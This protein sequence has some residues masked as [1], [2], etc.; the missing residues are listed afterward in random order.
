M[1]VICV[2]DNHIYPDVFIRN[3]VGEKT[4][5]EIILKRVSVKERF[6]RFYETLPEREEL[7][8]FD[9][10]WEYENL[11]REI[12]S[13][14]KD[15]RIIH[16]FS[17]QIVRD[18][19]RDDVRILFEKA[20]LSDGNYV[21]KN[22][23]KN[24]AG[25]I[26]RK[27]S[28]YLEFLE[29]AKDRLTD[30]DVYQ[31]YRFEFFEM[32]AGG[33]FDISVYSNFRNYITGGFDARFFN[34]F[35]GDEY[36]VK[37]ISDKKEK[38][39]AEY[40]FYGLLPDDMKHWF[41]MPYDYGE[42]EN[43]AFYSM[44]RYHMTDLA[45][46]FVHGAIDLKEFEKLMQMVFY[47]LDSRAAKDISD[48]EYKTTADTLYVKKVK[49]RIEA[50]KKHPGYEKIRQL[51]SNRE[52][53]L[54]D[55]LLK[56]YLDL[57]EKLTAEEKLKSISVIGHGDLCFSN[58]LFDKNTELLMLIDPKGA[59]KEEDLWTDPYY[60]A[61]KLSHSV[62]GRYD[63]FNNGLYRFDLDDDLRPVL[64]IE[65]DNSEYV[66]VFREYL[67]R[68]GFSCRLV[69]LY[70]ASLFLSMLPLHMDYPKKVFGFMKNAEMILEELEGP[71]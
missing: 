29:L 49:S 18:D 60:D 34:S 22:E 53:E 64:E 46:R 5:G 31:R 62:C 40:T 48:K 28:D 16:I 4:F 47:F 66:R 9:H 43:T 10:D 2:Y 13:L 54:I 19:G 33:F 44:K 56:R 38:I 7:F 26:M 32:T 52:G 39:K 21:I 36:V 24:T 1:A 45:V 69:R 41:V 27:T 20:G 67:E 55:G 37:K 63:L 12:R 59:L 30:E 6:M 65:F 50:L 71:G 57:Y 15:S 8:E 17:S 3:M 61:A 23:E 51:S 25:F 42:D 35:A 70:E 14:S 58:M 11:K 68:S